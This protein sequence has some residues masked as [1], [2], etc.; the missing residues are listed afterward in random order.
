[1][2]FLLFYIFNKIARLLT[3]LIFGEIFLGFLCRRS[4]HLFIILV[5]FLP[6]HLYAFYSFFLVVQCWLETKHNVEKNWHHWFVSDFKVNTFN[7]SLLCTIASLC[8]Y[9]TIYIQIDMFLFIKLRTFLAIPGIY[10]M[11]IMNKSWIVL[12]FF[13]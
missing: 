11:F 12:N 9:L 2:N 4:Y 3:L 5:L 10:E 7:I 6:S 1:M 13:M 8:I